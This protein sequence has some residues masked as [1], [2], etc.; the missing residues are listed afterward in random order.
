MIKR[1]ICLLALM[2]LVPVSIF[3]EQAQSGQMPSGWAE[4]TEQAPV[5]V[6]EFQEMSLPDYLET[7]V[8]VLIKQVK[9]PLRLFA[10][11]CAILLLAGF[12]RELCS[13]GESGFSSVLDTVVTLSAFSLCGGAILG[14][15]SVLEQAVESSRV[16]LVSFIPVFAAAMAAGGQPTG[17]ALY[18]GLF[19]AAS[20]LVANL[21]CQMGLP[22]SKAFLAMDAAG[23]VSN[24]INLSGLAHAMR[25]WSKWLL[26]FCATVFTA[27][28]TL[29]G[30]FAQSTDSLAL[31][32]GKFLLSSSVPVVGRAVSDAMG[33]V[34]A[35]IRLMKGTLGF[36]AVAVV[37][38]L[39]APLLIQCLLYGAAFAGGHMV[40]SATGDEKS[41]RLFK[42][43]ADSVSL[44]AAMAFFFFFVVTSATIL[45][46]LFGS[47]G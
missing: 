4:V 5:T 40:A 14:L 32:T 6:E 22:L 18:S 12:A 21:L 3:A 33:G 36:A 24:G 19:F 27:L 20:S 28:M 41:A 9:E 17:A 38:A 42:G 2:C 16:Y 37:T 31:K 39:F 13:G 34:L 35:G 10:K 11:V 30:V 23:C 26:G 8:D 47:G 45:M 1:F 46:I 43:L 44:C 7:I 25:R 15:L 29:Q